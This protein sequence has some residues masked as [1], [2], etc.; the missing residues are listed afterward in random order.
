MNDTLLKLQALQGSGC[1]L[2]GYCQ[3]PQGSE[4]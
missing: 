1:L 2:R 3:V 4:E